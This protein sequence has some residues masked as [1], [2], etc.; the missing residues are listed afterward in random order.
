MYSR[1]YG[2]ANGQNGQTYEF[3]K[4][5]FDGS[6]ILGY[7]FL[8]DVNGVV[9]VSL[10]QREFDLQMDFNINAYSGE[11]TRRW[12]LYGS[13]GGGLPIPGKYQVFYYR[14][15]I[16]ELRQDVT[17][18]PAVIGFP[19][20]VTWDKDGNDLTINW[21]PP[22][23][24]ESEIWYKVV[25]FS[26]IAPLTSQVFDRDPDEARLA[27][28]PLEASDRAEV[29]VAVFFNEGY[30]CAENESLECYGCLEM[31]SKSRT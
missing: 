30:A 27:D 23:L 5:C 16:E 7:C 9:V 21:Q 11:V 26:E 4:N 17:H 25:V 29:N 1:K 24:V 10:D 20:G 3:K 15:G 8:L 22:K 12:V 18:T 2:P 31:G 6:E 19:N 13:S 28:V 14:D